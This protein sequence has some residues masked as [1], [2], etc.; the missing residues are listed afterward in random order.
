LPE[1]EGLRLNLKTEQLAVLR[2][3]LRQVV[4][5]RGT[6]HLSSLEHWE[7]AGKTGTAQNPH[8]RNH[9]WFVGMAGPRDG[10]PEIVIAAIVEFGERGSAT[11]NY[12]AKVADYYL[13]TRYGM[14]IDEV[15]TLR[16][17]LN[18]GRAAP[19]ARWQ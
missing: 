14:E 17:H 4:A 15:Q 3:G 19:W 6:A 7:L 5:P 12:V 18:A 1:D 10:E 13:R 11:A 9:G 8:G 2:Q 16:D